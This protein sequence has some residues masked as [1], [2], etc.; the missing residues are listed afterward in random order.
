MNKLADMKK[1]LNDIG[2]PLSQQSDLCCYTLL[3]MLQ[4]NEKMDWSQAN[5]IWIRIHDIIQFIKDNYGIPYAENSRETF[6]KQAIHHFR[7]AALI[8]DN[9]QATNSP[10]YRYRVTDEALALIRS[11]KTPQWHEFL[12]NFLE[13]HEKLINMYASQK[14]MKKMPVKINGKDL[15]FSPGKHNELQKIDY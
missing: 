1:F 9:G 10:N 6:R 8:E 15:T 14:R 11:I 5:S 2:M 12:N 3:A 4:I 7:N 13:K